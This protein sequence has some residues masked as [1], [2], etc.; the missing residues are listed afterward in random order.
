M[1][2]L[3]R[4]TTSLFSRCNGGV[5]GG[6]VRNITDLKKNSPRVKKSICILSNGATI[7]IYTSLPYAPVWRSTIDIFSTVP[8]YHFDSI[9]DIKQKR[10]KHQTSKYS[11]FKKKR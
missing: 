1:N 7:P 3:I 5:I 10:R 8:D 4:S 2:S 11:E 9:K 6:L